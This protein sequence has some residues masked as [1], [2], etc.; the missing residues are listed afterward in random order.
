M[1]DVKEFF[2]Y[3]QGYLKIRVWGY[4]PERFM[5]LC[6]NRG[7][8][9]WDI[10]RREADYLMYISLSGF[11]RLRPVVRKTGTRV[12]ILE[13]C[14]L[15][16]LLRRMRKR[17]VF[18]MGL[19]ACLAFLI[20]MSRF[21]WAIDFEGNRAVTDDMLMDFLVE[22]GVEY[23]TA[24]S[25]IDIERLEEKLRETFD[26]IT[27]T[28][29][30]IDGT[31]LIVNVRE[32][33]LVMTEEETKEALDGYPGS[34]LLAT[35]DGTVV[36]ILTRKGVPQ[37]T[38]GME[39]KKGDILVSGAVPVLADDGTVREYQYCHA[40]ADVVVSYE[41]TYEET[42][43]LN[44]E[45]KNYTGREKKDF[46]LSFGGRQFVFR[47]GGCSFLKY[48]TV[49]DARQLKVLG[50]IYLPF[51]FGF[52]VK[53]EYLEVEAVYQKEQAEEILEGRLEKKIEGLYDLGVQ[54][55]Q[56]NVT[57]NTVGGSVFLN[58]SLD[59]EGKTGQSRP[60][61]GK[62]PERADEEET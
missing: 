48:D 29:V 3:L 32:N 42:L 12:A 49:M 24:R 54:I 61:S 21:I 55:M 26:G 37:V 59:V 30:T 45:Y 6:S 18:V 2:R 50:Q 14:G 27:W 15:P 46:F 62:Q 20:I 25:G 56:K 4:S 58:A 38:A 22:N 34:D 9:L 52:E 33:D 7:I 57:I 35:Q 47:L 43:A 51:Y 11:F 28:S 36:S 19:P 13:R 5:N 10:T 44:Y 53:R 1:L 17:K 39:V 16:F 40:D 31:R 60:P 41:V 8:L 23:G